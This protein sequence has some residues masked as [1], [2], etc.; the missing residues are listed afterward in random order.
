MASRNVSSILCELWLEHEE[1]TLNQHVKCSI[2]RRSPAGMFLQLFKLGE[3]SVTVEIFRP[4][5]RSRDRPCRSH[6]QR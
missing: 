5:R 6:V 3:A 2:P 4:P 1:P